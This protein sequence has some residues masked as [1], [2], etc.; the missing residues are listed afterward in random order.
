MRALP[1]FL[2]SLFMTSAPAHAAWLHLCPQPA[3]QAQMPFAAPFADTVGEDGARLR[4]S[5]D[6]EGERAGCTSLALPPGARVETLFPLAP[7]EQIERTILLHGRVREGRFAVSEHVLPSSRPA[8]AAPGPMPL[9][10]N[11]L[12]LEGMQ[13]RAFGVE[14]RVRVRREGGRL[15]IDCGAGSRPAGV[16]LSGPWFLPRARLRLAASYA[17]GAGF[18]LQAA[19]AAHAERE[20]ALGLGGLPAQRSATAL[21]LPLP[22]A[23]ARESWRHFVLQCPAQAASLALDAL[24]L[25]P[26]PLMPLTSAPGRSTWVWKAADWRDHGPRL[27]DWAADHRVRDLFITI[28][29][30]DDAVQ[31]PARLAAFVRAAGA[32]GMRVLSVDGDPH[33]VLPGQQAALARMVRAYA[34]YNAG[35]APDARLAGLQFDVEPYLL[36]EYGAGKVDWDARYL[37][38]AHTLRD[39]AGSLRLELVVPFWWDGKTALLERLAPLVDALAVMDYRTDPAQVLGFAVPF[40]DWGARHGRQVRIALEAGPIAPETQRRYVSATAA[41][42]ADLLHLRIGGQQVL[43]LLSEPMAGKAV[44]SHRIAGRRSAGHFRLQSTREIDGSA[45]TF[46]RDKPGLLRLLPDLE[47]DFSAWDG[48]FG[49]IALHELR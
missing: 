38:M 25:E 40:L 30:R 5:V 27:L 17:G 11:L 34:A 28:P 22:D 37:A 48:A 36:P 9:H 13:A 21:R 15:T 2:L 42:P 12:A 26:D 39:A 46:H 10:A 49:G 32:R 6:S 35:A 43:A 29:F 1:F 3:V 47:T 45:T 20:T 16:L 24:S 18:S 44:D 19:D 31:E 33:M 4:W 41:E 14:E 7:G 8:A 23:L